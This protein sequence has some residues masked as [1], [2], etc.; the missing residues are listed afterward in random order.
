MATCPLC[1]YDLSEFDHGCPRCFR[2]VEAMAARWQEEV[3]AEPDLDTSVPT[4]KPVKV[5][6]IEM[7][8]KPRV[9]RAE[10]CV[11]GAFLG[12]LYG[13]VAM[14]ALGLVDRLLL[15]GSHLRYPMPTA[16]LFAALGGAWLGGLIG[17]ATVMTRSVGVGI[18]AGAVVLGVAKAS[19]SFFARFG[20]KFT[21]VSLFLGLLYGLIIGALVAF[22]VMRTV[23][24]EKPE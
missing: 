3:P 8:P 4:E 23:K 20:A 9:S 13:V 22:A 24:W 19:E 2:E 15:G 18:A 7:N 12:G 16:L 17:F 11:R 10:L 21:P 6:E 14:V 1:G 5:F